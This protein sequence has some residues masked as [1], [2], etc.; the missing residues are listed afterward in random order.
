MSVPQVDITRLNV[1]AS[2]SKT[3][4]TMKLKQIKLKGE[5]QQFTVMVGEVNT[6]ISVG[7]NKE[8]EIQH[9]VIITESLKR[10]DVW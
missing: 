8:N 9:D 3:S 4:K 5:I 10:A 6:P 2:N 1:H 7:K